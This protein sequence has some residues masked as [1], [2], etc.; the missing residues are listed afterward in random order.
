MPPPAPNG[1]NTSNTDEN[2]KLE[3]CNENVV[4]VVEPG[5]NGISKEVAEKTT[6]GRTSESS[7]AKEKVFSCLSI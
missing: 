3:A 6:T 4:E 5:E 2:G 7:F 1:T